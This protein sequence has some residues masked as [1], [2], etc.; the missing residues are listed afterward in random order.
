MITTP[1]QPKVSPGL[2]LGILC[3]SLFAIALTQP[4]LGAPRA[5]DFRTPEACISS[6]YQ[7]L[8]AQDVDGVWNCYTPATQRLI[9]ETDGDGTNC[10]KPPRKWRDGWLE[11]FRETRG[12]RIDFRILSRKWDEEFKVY[13]FD[14]DVRETPPPLNEPGFY[15][16]IV[17]ETQAGWKMDLAL[18]IQGITPVA[19][20][21]GQAIK[22]AYPRRPSRETLG[23]DPLPG[24]EDT[25]GGHDD[26]GGHGGGND[27]GGHGE[28]GDD[29]GHQDNDG[30]HGGGHG[31]NED[32][33][34]DRGNN[35][36]GN[37][38]DGQLRGNPPVNDGPGTGPG[39]P[40]NKGGSKR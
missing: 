31:A 20:A 3:W 40:G 34:D 15:P 33:D 6:Y 17:Q 39:N 36:V 5:Y 35:G 24:E 32:D 27:D 12:T 28:D 2:R 16:H 29:G 21:L 25:G 1:H 30:G 14:V 38:Q 9:C 8:N 23:L 4:S 37:G 11:G 22:G 18:F 13:T 7:A 26:D 10:S 19:K